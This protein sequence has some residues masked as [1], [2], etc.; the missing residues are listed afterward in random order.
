LAWFMCRK[1]GKKYF[2]G[3]PPKNC[4]DCQAG[5]EFFMK[6]REKIEYDI[7]DYWLPMLDEKIERIHNLQVQAGPESSS[8]GLITDIHW[9][10]NTHHSAALMEEVLNQCA[11]P[12]FFNAGDTVSGFGLCPKESLFEDI[13]NYRRSFM[14]IEHKCLMVEGNHDS[15][16]STFEAPNYYA[17][18]V[19]KDELYEHLFR[20]ETIYPDRV[21]GADGTYYYVDDKCHKMRY[22]VLNSHDIP[23]EET[24]ENNIPVYNKFRMTAIRQ[25][26]LEWFAN[27]ALDVPSDDWTVTLCTHENPVHDWEFYSGDMIIGILNAFKNHTKFDGATNIGES[28]YETKIS[29]DFT[30]RGGYFTAWVCGHFH[31]SF[32]EVIDGINCISTLND[33]LHQPGHSP[34]TRTEGT[35]TEHA[36]DIFTVDK[37]KRKIFI[38]RIGAGVDREIDY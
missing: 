20:F 10:N 17:E 31:D 32:Y 4:P 23:S 7:P 1:C 29:V 26:Q 21:F 34:Y 5:Q 27:I 12:Y 38:T 28:E 14:R 37:R 2:E 15:A 18:N 24:D 35:D 36:F 6:I 8:F 19:T 16:Y 25:E 3:Y 22:I 13:D 9:G 30:G 11:I 33:S